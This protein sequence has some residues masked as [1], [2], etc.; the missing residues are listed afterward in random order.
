MYCYSL[1]SSI[2]I[3]KKL[4][5]RLFPWSICPDSFYVD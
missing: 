5:Y 1:T 3:E 4:I 2:E